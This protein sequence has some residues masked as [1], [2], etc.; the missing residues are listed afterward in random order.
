MRSRKEFKEI[1]GDFFR[2]ISK[3]QAIEKMAMDFGVGEKLYPSEIHMVEAIGRNPGINVT[4]LAERM[5]I[6][7]GAVPKRIRKLEQKKLVRR[8]QDRENRKEVYFR[9]T[10]TGAIAFK[11]HEVFHDRIDRSFQSLLCRMNN[12]A[13]SVV[14]L[15]LTELDRYTDRIIEQQ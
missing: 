8:Y 2:I 15:V 7:K 9:L 3:F 6:T 4:G 13:I 10:D 11:A 14:K 12:D 1:S 5:G